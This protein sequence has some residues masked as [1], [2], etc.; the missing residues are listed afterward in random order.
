MAGG[1][2]FGADPYR[3]VDLARL[4][5]NSPWV[6]VTA[7]LRL[8]LWF[9]GAVILVAVLVGGLSAVFKDPRFL[10]PDYL[11]GSK[12]GPWPGIAITLAI[13]LALLAGLRAAVVKSQRRPFMS[14]VAADGR[15]DGRRLLIGGAAWL[16][17]MLVAIAV[18]TA[19]QLALDPASVAWPRSWPHGRDLA[20]SLL[21]FVLVIPLQAASEELLFRG[22][23]TQTLGQ[24]IRQPVILVLVVAVLFALFHG[25]AAGPLALPYYMIV[26]L[27][28]S[29]LSLGDGRLETAIGAHAAQNLFVLLIQ[30]PFANPGEAPSLLAGTHGEL[31]IATLVTAAAQTVLAF[32]FARWLLGRLAPLQASRRPPVSSSAAR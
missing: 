7:A 1:G 6:L 20:L 8:L 2:L 16:L 3:Y 24:A 29:L 21:L 19:V 27:L 18:A 28:L 14:L 4:G 32:V 13:T 5:R 10:D 17:A 12:A 25:F 15:L 31:G 11:L 22:W 30:L 26:S 9:F 23:L